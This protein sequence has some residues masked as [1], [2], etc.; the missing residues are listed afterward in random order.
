[1]ANGSSSIF[2][3]IPSY[4]DPDL[5]H[6]LESAIRMS[7]G[8][9]EVRLSVC[10]QLTSYVEAF[11]LSRTLPDHVELRATLVG[12]RLIGLG[13][14]RRLA[15]EW[16]AGEEYQIQLDAH[17]RFDADWDVRVLQTMDRLGPDA[18]GS[19]VNH[20][21]PWTARGKVVD[22]QFDSIDEYLILR[23]EM[24][25]IEPSTGRLDEALPA[26]SIVPGGMIGAAWCEEV[27]A[28]PHIY[29]WGDEA[30]LGVRLWTHGRTLW[31][32]QLP[33]QTGNYHPPMRP[34]ER[35]EWAEK[36]E[37]SLR[38]ARSL[39][40]GD[41]LAADDPAGVDM[42]AFGLGTARTLDDWV[43]F[44]GIDYK[45]GVVRPEWPAKY[46]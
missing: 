39:V 21:D 22:R 37:L 38:R 19:N 31:H 23:G 9:H 43:E 1:M 16:Y 41:P 11:S 2:V 46:A 24:S 28:D 7:S 8:H 30:T 44:S 34:W 14:A 10:E 27:Q 25:M 13:G 29:Y 18:I 33:W 5:P 17:I 4:A 42:D 45:T 3:V 12:D 15:E 32:V 35:P 40:T 36:V 26:R 6:S 20:S